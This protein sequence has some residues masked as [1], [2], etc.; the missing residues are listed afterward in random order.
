MC[1]I[2]TEVYMGYM[3]LL[4]GRYW[5]PIA[6]WKVYFT[7]SYRPMKHII[8]MY[9]LYFIRFIPQDQNQQIQDT[10]PEVNMD[11]SLLFEVYN[12]YKLSHPTCTGYESHYKIHIYM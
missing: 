9:T 2:Y 4:H 7:D 8:Y 12:N 5:Q 1:V 6:S 3:N 10:K 11:F